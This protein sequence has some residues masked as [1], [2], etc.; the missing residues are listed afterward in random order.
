MIISGAAQML[1]QPAVPGAPEWVP[2]GAV[3]HLDFTNGQYFAG[4]AV[5]SIGTLLGGGFD[6]GEISGA[7]MLMG[8]GV[9]NHPDAAGALLTDI[10]AQFADGLTMV[11]DIDTQSGWNGTVLWAMNAATSG[12]ATASFE[13]SGSSSSFG[14][15]DYNWLSFSGGGGDLLASG[16]Q[17]FAMTMNRDLGGSNYESAASVNGGTVFSG[18]TSGNG[19][20]PI[21]GNFHTV[22]LFHFEGSFEIE[23][24]I[25]VVTLYPAVD[26]AELPALSA[27]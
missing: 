4:G 17:K 1:N 26:N 24:H 9:S 6:P 8:S 16:V 20:S 21:A 11:V 19:P 13:I 2:D 7:G 18:D 10:A 25:R 12:A 3:A 23:G 14:M 5:R 22:N 27:I 15:S